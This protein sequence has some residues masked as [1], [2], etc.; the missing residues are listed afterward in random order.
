MHVASV[1][2]P[3]VCQQPRV[4]MPTVTYQQP[5][6]MS[7]EQ[8]SIFFQMGAPSVC[9]PFAASQLHAASPAMA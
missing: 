4:A 2:V 1:A 3:K 6:P 8:L 5:Q 9:Q 7:P